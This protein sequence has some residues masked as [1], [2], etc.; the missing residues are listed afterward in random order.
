MNCKYPDIETYRKVF[1]QKFPES[2]ISLI[3]F[4]PNKQIKVQNKYGICI[5]LRQGV[6]KQGSVTIR[7]SIDPTNYFINQ[8]IAIHG[9]KYS[10]DKVHWR[11]S[12]S[13]I[14]VYCKIHKEYFTQVA[15]DHLNKCG[16]PKCGNI[17]TSVRLTKPESLYVKQITKIHKGKYSIEKG[18]YLGDG[19]KI[20][21]FCDIQKEW[22]NMKPSHVL[23]GH[24]CSQCGNLKKSK[25]HRNNPRGWSY[26]AWEKAGKK[27]KNFDSFKVY[28]I[29]CTD[30]TNNEHFFKIGKTYNTVKIRYQSKYE[31]PYTWKLVKE[32]IG[33]AGEISILEKELQTKNRVHKYIPKLEFQ[34]M[35]E[36][37]SEIN[38]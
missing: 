20:L 4:L 26:S 21:H 34:G 29:E 1:N 7:S 35:Y 30:L 18:S 2:D 25:Y 22:F 12:Y 24:G 36:C 37:F 38:Y 19:I 6:M 9:D 28:V 11:H 27:S 23:A 14:S 13:L 16:C 32:F 15:A 8:C 5:T 31:M 10:Y 17:S 33:T 3:E